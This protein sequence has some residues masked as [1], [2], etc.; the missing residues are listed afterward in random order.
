M[1]W[2]GRQNPILRAH[3]TIAVSDPPRGQNSKVTEKSDYW[4]ALVQAHHFMD[5]NKNY[6]WAKHLIPAFKRKGLT[7]ICE[8]K[9]NMVYVESF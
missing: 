5:Y 7:D 2:H 4:A 9:A 6:V 8:S 3:I 1:Q